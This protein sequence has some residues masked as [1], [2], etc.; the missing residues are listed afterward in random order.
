MPLTAGHTGSF[1]HRGDASAQLARPSPAYERAKRVLDVALAGVSL[2]ALSPVLL[3]TAVAIVVD[4]GLPVIYA[5]PRKGKDGKPFHM[6][7]F[8]SMHTG[9]E[10]LQDDMAANVAT[11]PFTTEPG[12]ADAFV[13]V[14]DETEEAAEATNLAAAP[15]TMAAEPITM[16]AA[17]ATIA[18]SPRP[19]TPVPV[20]AAFKAVDDPRVTRVGR[21]IRKYF[22]DELPQLVNVLKGDMSIVGPRAIQQTREY[23]AYERQRLAVRPG[24][25]CLW[26]VSGNRR[27]PW[28]EWVE[29]DLRYIRT[30][31][32][33]TD[34]AIIAKT[35]A[36]I[37]RGEGDI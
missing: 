18:A 13:E 24:L 14:K 9:A 28:H 21:F 37:L 1:A 17:P 4:D 29:L 30:R 23:T 8:R 20:S 6:Y 5:A 27:M 15:T 19:A 22:I 33:R 3:I 12:L 16:A 25:T 34:A 2:V 36:V 35:F 31:S 7:K 11:T 32:L 10:R 26:Q